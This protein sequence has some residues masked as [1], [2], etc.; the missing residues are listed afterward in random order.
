VINDPR[1]EFAELHHRFRSTL[2]LRRQLIVDQWNEL[3]TVRW[4][5]AGVDMLQVWVHQMAGS[6]ASFGYPALGEYARELECRLA[7]VAGGAAHS[8][9]AVA[10]IAASVER[11]RIHIDRVL[12]MEPSELPVP[13]TVSAAENASRSLI[14]VVDGDADVL[15]LLASCLR[16]QGYRVKTYADPDAML[17]DLAG[18]P[19]TTILM[20]VGFSGGRWK[21]THAINSIRSNSRVQIPVVLISARTDIDARLLA[22]RAGAAA[23]LTK[24]VDL[25]DLFATMHLA[26]MEGANNPLRVLVVDDDATAG[27]D[28]A[29]VLRAAGMTVSVLTQPKLALQV[30]PGFRPDVA[31]VDLHLPA[32]SGN[33][34]VTILSDVP[35]YATLPVVCLSADASEMAQNRAFEL[36]AHFFLTKSVS[37]REL[38]EAL[39]KCVLENER[40]SA[41]LGR[42]THREAGRGAVSREAFLSRLDSAIGAPAAE[43]SS[44]ALVYLALDQLAEV[45]GRYGVSGAMEV[46]HGLEKCVSAMVGDVD[47]WFVLGT[48][49]IAMLLGPRPM[50]SH[51]DFLAGLERTIATNGFWIGRERLP[52]T[53]SAVLLPLSPTNGSVN[54]VLAR[55]EH[56]ERAASRAGGN[57][58][59]VI[60][61]PPPQELDLQPT[62]RGLPIDQL[63]LH[64]QPIV[65]EQGAEQHIY[66]VLVRLRDPSGAL[67]PARMFLPELAAMGLAAQLDLWVMGAAVEHL[68]TMPKVGRGIELAVR[69]STTSLDSALLVPDVRAIISAISNC[70]GNRLVFQIDEEWLALHEVAGIELV[71][72]LHDLG[73]GAMLCNF[74]GTEHPLSKAWAGWFDYA[75]IS[76]RRLEN[77]V[78][79]ADERRAVEEMIRDAAIRGALIIACQIDSE[80][81]MST[82][83]SWGVRLF[84]SKFEQS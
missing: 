64:L 41:L 33:E 17:P 72:A 79:E 19:P 65:D 44:A 82:L 73:C 76:Q 80:Q 32:C 56:A 47:D 52:C 5:I 2:G 75:K 24:P 3:R 22:L 20:D 66:D 84:E 30:L 63:A 39:R 10:G 67:L 8:M 4:S 68:A 78:S 61:R 77:I 71:V 7:G 43:G 50:D 81:T 58:Y 11:L 38:V 59:L 70:S 21:G 57:Q 49:V 69:L 35:E 18:E 36:G 46:Q 48:T 26:C 31:L 15:E 16:T 62:G 83:R 14:Y 74:G 55:V 40:R 29:A 51:R 6:S 54:E 23:Y 13:Q 42:A 12:A 27:N 34:L 25:R 28:H 45:H 60:E 53:A 37:A 9:D 1:Q